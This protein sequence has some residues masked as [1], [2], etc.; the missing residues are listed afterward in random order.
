M[1]SE[2]CSALFL[3]ENAVSVA[4]PHSVSPFEK[5]LELRRF[6]PLLAPK[7][8]LCVLAD[9]ALPREMTRICE[10]DRRPCSSRR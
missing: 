1:Q 3:L 7:H 8:A 6:S 4:D 2:G 9:V 10:Q 5:K